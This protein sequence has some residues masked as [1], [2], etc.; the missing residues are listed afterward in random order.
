MPT[1]LKIAIPGQQEFIWN[2]MLSDKEVSQ[3]SRKKA[4]ERISVGPLNPFSKEV[5]IN[6]VMIGTLHLRTPKYST[7]ILHSN[8]VKFDKFM[9]T[10]EN[11][12]LTI[13]GSLVVK[14]SLKSDALAELKA[15]LSTAHFGQIGIWYPES[16]SVRNGYTFTKTGSWKEDVALEKAI[17]AGKANHGRELQI[18]I[19]STMPKKS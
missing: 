5:V 7:T 16:F 1:F 4:I 3:R 14:V 9:A 10:I 12:K 19:S 13:K 6:E 17:F 2:G 11:D 15:H 18:E 8:V